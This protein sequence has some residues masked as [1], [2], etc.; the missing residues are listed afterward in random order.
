MPD[1]P[2][3]TAVPENHVA[4]CSRAEWRAWLAAHHHRPGGVWLVLYKK[5]AAAPTLSTDDVV[6]EAIAFGWIDSVPKKLDAERWMLW[7][8]PRQAGSNWSR[9]SKTRAARMEQAGQMA[10]AGRAAIERAR[11]DGSW[12]SLDEVED[13]VV[14]GDLGAALAALPPARE[15]WD[16]FPPSTRR[17]ILEWILNARREAT[18]AAR[19]ETTARLAQVGKRANQW[20]GD[21]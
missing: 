2:G 21:E 18:R 20:P 13:L 7:V 11:A 17:G 16:A 8:A 10:D 3:T 6:E 9:L 19:I 5:A 15:C 12:A 1:T 14:P 4:P